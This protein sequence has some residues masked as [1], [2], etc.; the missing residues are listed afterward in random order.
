VKEVLWGRGK[1]LG[2]KENLI[3]RGGNDRGKVV[4]E[5]KREVLHRIQREVNVRS[6]K[7]KPERLPQDKEKESCLKGAPKR[8]I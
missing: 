8:T 4:L 1:K 2:G 3:K 6:R 5:G 7:G